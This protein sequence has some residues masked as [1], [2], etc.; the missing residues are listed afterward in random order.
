MGREKGDAKRG[1]K[2]E[3]LASGLWGEV[4]SAEKSGE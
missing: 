1:R 2:S 4:V 3:D